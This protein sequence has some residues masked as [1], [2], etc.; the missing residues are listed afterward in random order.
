MCHD[1]GIIWKT[2]EKCLE[3]LSTDLYLL[4]IPVTSDGDIILSCRIHALKFT[5]NHAERGGQNEL[6]NE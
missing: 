5:R 6:C 3:Y 2:L 1:H 4:V